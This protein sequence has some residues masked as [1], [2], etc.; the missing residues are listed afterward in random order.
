M[1]NKKEE[2]IITTTYISKAIRKKAK[3]FAARKGISLSDLMEQALTKF[4][5]AT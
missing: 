4:V 3:V 2:K 1:E 5:S